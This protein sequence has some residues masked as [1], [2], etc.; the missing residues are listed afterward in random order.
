MSAALLTTSPAADTYAGMH[1]T[2][3]VALQK[4]QQQQQQQQQHQQQ[5]IGSLMCWRPAEQ[6]PAQQKW[7][8]AQPCSMGS[9]L[10]NPINTAPPPRRGEADQTATTGEKSQSSYIKNHVLTV[11]VLDVPTCLPVPAQRPGPASPP[12]C[13]HPQIAATLLQDIRIAST[14]QHKPA[15]TKNI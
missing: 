2:T 14:I 15:A 7:A 10:G 8:S 5:V 13:P 3:E 9:E 1:A 11:W 6:T 4:Q 12:P